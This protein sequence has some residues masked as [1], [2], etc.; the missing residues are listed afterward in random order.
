VNCF[1]FRAA[2]EA[3]TMSQTEFA[4]LLKVERSTV[5]RWFNG[6]REVPHYAIM[7]LSA[8]DGAGSAELRS[9][10]NVTNCFEFG[11]ALE[12]GVMSQTEFASL[13]RVERSTVWRWFSG[14]REVPQ[15]AMVIL[16]ALA[17]AG[18]AELR[19]G[20]LRTFNIQ[21]H[22]VYLNGETFIDLAMRW[23]PDRSRRETNAE[24]QLVN[25]YRT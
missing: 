2:L 17:G 9:T 24:M 10:P 22:H 19:S 21:R 16:S 8:L 13:L 15:Y 23:H 20:R 18:S 5:W 14:K 25:R 1:E 11:A 6:E 3:V 4:S 12:A 7:I